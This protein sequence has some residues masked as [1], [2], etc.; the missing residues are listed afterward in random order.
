MKIINQEFQEKPDVG[1]NYNTIYNQI[2]EY[3]R[4]RIDDEELLNLIANRFNNVLIQETD[5]KSFSLKM[6]NGSLRANRMPIS[7]GALK[8]NMSISVSDKELDIIPGIALRP[9]F[10]YQQLVHEFV[11]LHLS[12]QEFLLIVLKP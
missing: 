12:L 7:A 8:T 2:M 1:D 5:G 6:P 11:L 4:T 10:T 9:N 3:L